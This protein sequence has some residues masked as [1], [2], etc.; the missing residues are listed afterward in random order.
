MTR[1]TLPPTH[2]RTRVCIH[3]RGGIPL[4]VLE[5]LP[6]SVAGECIDAAHGELLRRA[7]PGAGGDHRLGYLLGIEDPVDQK[8]PAAVELD[9]QVRAEFVEPI[10]RETQRRYAL[11]F[12]K[13]LEGAPPD[14]LEGVLHAGYHLD[15]HP[16]ITE[17]H[18]PELARILINLASTPRRFRFAQTD[19]FLLAEH[20][21]PMHRGSY[22]VVELPRSVRESMIEIPGRTRES[23]FALRFWASVIPHVGIE[24]GRGHFLASYEAVAEFPGSP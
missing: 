9:R 2:A 6:F 19:R 1:E 14:A 4:L 16:D 11:S 17:E 7:D 20:G 24:D 3:E 23:A 21:F 12:L 8:L 15:T 10:A 22:Q 18:G 13:T 5:E